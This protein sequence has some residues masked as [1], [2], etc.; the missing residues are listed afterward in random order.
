MP[1]DEVL[2]VLPETVVIDYTEQLI[3]LSEQVNIM[4]CLISCILTLLVV[5]LFIK[6]MK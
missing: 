2:E 6:G 5:N 1:A 4:I 3:Y